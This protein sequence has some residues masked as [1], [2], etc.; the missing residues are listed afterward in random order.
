M[1]ELWN[2]RITIRR[3]LTVMLG[4]ILLAA[5]LSP[6]IRGQGPRDGSA[7]ANGNEY[8]VEFS[9]AGIPV[10]LSSRIQ[11]L[12]GRLIDTLPELNI[13]VVANLSDPAADA[14]AARSDVVGVTQDEHLPRVAPEFVRAFEHVNL[15]AAPRS[16]EY[17]ALGAPVRRTPARLPPP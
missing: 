11:A 3:P 7:S 13:A 9:R 14:L 16:V 1:S 15:A 4:A 8:L 10:D 5:G 6:S 2:A 17:A 12:G